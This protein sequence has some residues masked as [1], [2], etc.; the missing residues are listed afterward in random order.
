MQSRYKD[1]WV[2]YCT[3]TAALHLQSQCL[4]SLQRQLMLSVVEQ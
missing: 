2:I 3:G 4:L 1:S